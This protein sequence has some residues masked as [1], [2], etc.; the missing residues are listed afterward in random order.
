[1]RVMPR[2]SSSLPLA[3][4]LGGLLL[5]T[6]NAFAFDLITLGIGIKGG[7]VGNFLDKPSDKSYSYMGSDVSNSLPSYPGFG[8]ANGEFGGYVEAM[9]L[10]MVGIELDFLHSSDFGHG[11]EDVTV[12]GLRVGTWNLQVGYDAWHIPLL[13]KGQIP[14]PLFSPYAVIGPE[15]VFPGKTSA[16]APPESGTT[17]TY[18][19]GPVIATVKNYTLFTVGLGFDI[20]LPIPNVDLRIPIDLRGS[21]NLGTSSHEQDLVNYVISGNTLQGATYNAAWQYRAS[22]T[23][24]LGYHF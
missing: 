13:L 22:A 6:S 23:I 2:L 15:F 16:S 10:G 3:A 21:F 11:S 7:A 5:T 8:G 20:K 12:N 1:M 19:N 9:A 4:V 18:P 24:G 17:G 14:L